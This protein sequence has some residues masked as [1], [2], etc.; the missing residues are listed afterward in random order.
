MGD[1]LTL[2]ERGL[3]MRGISPQAVELAKGDGA[4]FTIG[5]HGLHHGIED[6]HG[7]RHVAGIGGDAFLRRP[8]NAQLARCTADSG[9]AAA[10]L[11]LV[12]RHVGVVE[13]GASRP[14]KQIA[15]GR[16]LVAQLSARPG[17]DR[18]RQDRVI[19]PDNRVG[20]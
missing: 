1:D 2:F 8:H 15:A 20:G 11:T 9:A 4:G 5:P 16:R 17:L 10:R 13:I 18:P 7:D 14:L 19:A 3:D 6:A 12:A